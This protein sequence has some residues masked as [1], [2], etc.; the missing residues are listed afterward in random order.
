MTEPM[1]DAWV[2]DCYKWRGA[3]LTGKYRHWCHDWDGLPVDETTPEWDCC[4][5]FPSRLERVLAWPWWGW[6][7]VA[8]VGLAQV[9]WLWAG[10]GRW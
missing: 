5:C 1:S 7:A 8:A 2:E 9:A 4:S 3:V 6:V 10:G